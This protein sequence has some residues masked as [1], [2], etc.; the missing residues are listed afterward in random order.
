MLPR[1]PSVVTWDLIRLSL[2]FRVETLLKSE[3]R[4]KETKLQLNKVTSTE[5]SYS[6]MKGATAYM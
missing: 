4:L 3:T 2:V 5:Q 1:T 6:L